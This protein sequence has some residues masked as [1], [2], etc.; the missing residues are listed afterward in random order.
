M[1]DQVKTGPGRTLPEAPSRGTL[2]QFRPGYWLD[3]L[4]YRDS[5]FVGVDAFPSQAVDGRDNVVIRSSRLPGLIGVRIA[6]DGAGEQA[7]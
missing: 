1:H 7:I 4:R 5:Y 3:A 6:A 2:E